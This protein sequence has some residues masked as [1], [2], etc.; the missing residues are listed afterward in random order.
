MKLIIGLIA[1]MIVFL[2]GYTS[3]QLIVFEP[4]QPPP[5]VF[6]D[7]ADPTML[8][9]TPITMVDLPLTPAQQKQS[10]ES[11]EK[12]KNSV[13]ALQTL[14][15]AAPAGIKPSVDLLVSA[16]AAVRLP[17]ELLTIDLDGEQKRR[18]QN[19]RFDLNAVQ[20]SDTLMTPNLNCELNAGVTSDILL[21]NDSNNSLNCAQNDSAINRD[22]IFVGGAGDDIINDAFGSRIVNAGA[23]NDTITLGRGRSIIL[24]EEGWGQDKLTLDCSEAVVDKNEIPSS[25]PVPWTAN[26]VHFVIVSP[27]IGQSN[28][29][30]D[31]MVLKHKSSPDTLT[32]NDKCFT[33]ITLN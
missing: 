18:F 20:S 32:V 31:G 24:L 26:F 12:I 2:V 11:I 5:L 27:R 33:L 19:I 6:D 30:W 9:N 15:D 3:Y 4:T 16:V 29:E 13:A 7:A 10:D 21:G 8:A 28:L 14:A 17:P 23:G 1:L 22:Q 25:N